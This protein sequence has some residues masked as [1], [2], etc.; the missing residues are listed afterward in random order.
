MRVTPAARRL[1]LWIATLAILL[2]ALGGALEQA[3]EARGTEDQQRQHRAR[4][5]H[6]VV[7]IREAQQLR[8]KIAAEAGAE[9]SEARARELLVETIKARVGLD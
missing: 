9:L 7:L 1:T 5:D 2:A 4:I 8:Q 3:D 6:Q